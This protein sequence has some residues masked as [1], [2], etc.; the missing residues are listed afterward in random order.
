MRVLVTGATGFIG[1]EVARVLAER[2][3]GPRLLVRRPERGLLL[4]RFDAEL[5]HGD[6]ESTEGLER[7]V[8]GIDAIIHLG[9]RATF[10]EYRL[11]KP[12][13]VSGSQ[14]LIEAAT[15]AGVRTF[16]YG[17][18]MFVYDGQPEPIDKATP[19]R[20]RLGY[21]RAKLEAE[22]KLEAAAERSG[23]RFSA[24]RLPHVYGA[25]DLF[26]SK[27]SKGRLIVP[28]RGGNRFAHLHVHDAARLL[29]SAAEKGIEGSFPVSDRGATTWFDFFDVVRRYYPR[30]RFTRLP[31]S[32]AL[33]GAA[34]VRPFQLIRRQPTILTTDTVIGWN[35]N[36]E[37]RPETLWAELELQ[38][39]YPT[40]EEGIPAALDECVAF[41]WLHPVEDRLGS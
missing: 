1:Y 27:I 16:V 34:L 11:L 31:E 38:P 17:S 5:M 33:A 12:T 26:F 4:R 2:G 14:A 18:S 20:P 37:V 35:L 15:R 22:H 30:L 39:V 21:G 28:G 10:E 19:P 36:L 7:A 32:V 3:L 23:M 9:A 13:I 8:T 29:I 40:I 25:R 41:R 6:L 24:I